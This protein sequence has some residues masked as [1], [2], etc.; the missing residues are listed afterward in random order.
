V[1][2]NQDLEETTELW[3]Q[4]GQLGQCLFRKGTKGQV[5]KIISKFE[6]KNFCLQIINEIHDE[7]SET[8]GLYS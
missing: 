2:R 6:S 3:C 7:I 1:E 4:V 5:K 8:V